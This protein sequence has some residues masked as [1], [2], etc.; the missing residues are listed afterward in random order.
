MAASDAARLPIHELKPDDAE[1]VWPLSI[2]AGWNQIAA[3]W[4]L[5]IASGT[6]LGIKTAAGRWI[7][8]AL[9]L[10]LGP[11]ASWISMVLVTKPERGKGHGSAAAAALYRYHR[12]RP[13]GPWASTPPSSVGR[14]T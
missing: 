8:T 11:Q 2:E 14:S 4:R 6:A 9:S 13:V 3:D 10:P 7:A 1:S 5:M 12:V